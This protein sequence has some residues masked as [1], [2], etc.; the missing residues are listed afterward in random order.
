MRWELNSRLAACPNHNGFGQYPW[1]QRGLCCRDGLEDDPARVQ[2][3]SSHWNG[4]T[5]KAPAFELKLRGRSSPFLTAL[6]EQYDLTIAH[7]GQLCQ[8]VL[9][10]LTIANATIQISQLTLWSVHHILKTQKTLLTPGS[11]HRV[12][13]AP[14]CA[15]NTQRGFL[16]FH[17]EF[18]RFLWKV[19]GEIR[20]RE[21]TALLRD[22][23]SCELSTPDRMM[24]KD[25]TV[26]PKRR[27]TSA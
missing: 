8:D 23:F 2:L 25:G 1:R 17:G 16:F 14:L 12:L 3:N 18:G 11:F 6:H 15:T 10:K 13:R 22:H 24:Q 4:A 21:V 20:T 5:K 19:D 7:R 26:V 27:R 9:V